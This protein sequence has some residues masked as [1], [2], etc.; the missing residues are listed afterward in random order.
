LTLSPFGSTVPGF[1]FSEITRPLL[2]DFED[3]RRTFPKRQLAR[4]IVRFAAGSVIPVTLG[5]V[6]NLVVLA[7]T[8]TELAT[9]FA[10]ATSRLPSPVRS[11]IAIDQ[12][13]RPVR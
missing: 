13:S 6:H 1:G 8:E 11:A 10:V 7:S 4:A 9:E 2:T 3:A 12:G 5:T